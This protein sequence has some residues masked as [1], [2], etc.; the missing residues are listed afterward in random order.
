MF[1]THPR[2]VGLHTTRFLPSCAAPKVPAGG[3]A[4]FPTGGIPL[5]G[6]S[7]EGMCVHV[8]VAMLV[9]TVF[10]FACIHVRPVRPH[11]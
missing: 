1:S 8:H 7:K 11:G 6:T 3:V 10:A 4:V 2:L 9:Y 5:L